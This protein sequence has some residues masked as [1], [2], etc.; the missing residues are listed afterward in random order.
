MHSYKD[1]AEF[2]FTFSTRTLSY[3]LRFRWKQGVSENSE[4]L[5]KFEEDFQKYWL[6]CVLY[7]LVI[8]RCKKSLKT[9]YENLVHVYL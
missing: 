9:D 5:G 6:Y 2:H 8:E 3:A 7:L 1:N 4:Y